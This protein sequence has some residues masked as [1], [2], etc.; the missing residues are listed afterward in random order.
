MNTG[1]VKKRNGLVPVVIILLLLCIGLGA[2][3]AVVVMN[4]KPTPEVVVKAAPNS[5]TAPLSELKLPEDSEA[6]D[7][8]LAAALVDRVFSSTVTNEQAIEFTST[9]EFV[10]TYYKDHDADYPKVSPSTANGTYKVKGD[11][12]TLSSGDSFRIVGD[13]LIKLGTSLSDDED[14]VYFDLYQTKTSA[15]SIASAYNSYIIK[16]VKANAGSVPVEKAVIDYQTLICKVGDSHLTNADNYYCTIDTTIYLGKETADAAVTELQKTDKKAD[17]LS[18]CKTAAEVAEF[19]K[20]GTCNANY[21][22]TSK[23]N[24]IVRISDGDYRVT[25][26]FH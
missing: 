26:L 13:Y 19:S 1:P 15:P 23:A 5:I 12:I 16:Q 8:E 25:G 4:K 17:F 7:K 11:T 3:L 21:T 24:I 2:G 22:I 9:T 20:G 10:Y 18:Y 14:T 6:H